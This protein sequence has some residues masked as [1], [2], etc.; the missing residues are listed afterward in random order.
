[1]DALNAL[2]QLN[3][4]L[5][6]LPVT[7]P[8]FS[9]YGRVITGVDASHE[10]KIARD[11]VTISQNVTYEASVPVLEEAGLLRACLELDYYGQMPVQL[12]WCYGHNVALDGL[13]YH[14]GNEINVGLSDC[15][16]MLAQYNDIHWDAQPWLDSSAVKTF[17]VPAGTMFELYAWGLHFAPQHVSEK[18]GF[19][20]IVALPR[21]TNFPLETRPE[22]KGE[23][24]LLFARNKWLLVHP[25]A[26]S[27]VR[28]GAYVGIRGKNLKLKTLL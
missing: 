19:C 21:D 2:R 10:L 9:A 7:D 6:V 23:A 27:L 25:E 17:Y 24:A 15:V 12:G 3:P 22:P 8:A 20:N 28:D 18:A 5:N 11:D 4:E 1:M 14:K 26:E 16:V 13:E